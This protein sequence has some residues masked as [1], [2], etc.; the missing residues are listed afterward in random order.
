MKIISCYILFKYILVK[1]TYTLG[2]PLSARFFK[3]SKYHY[4]LFNLIQITG[5]SITR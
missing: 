3:A 5:Q 1:E 2:T 4:N